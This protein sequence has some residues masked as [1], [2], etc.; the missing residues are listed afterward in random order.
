M[1]STARTLFRLLA[2]AALT[3]VLTLSLA[4]SAASAPLGCVRGPAG[5]PDKAYAV[6]EH[7]RTHGSAPAG[8][9]GGRRFENREGHLDND[10]GPFREYDVNRQV[11]G[12]NR[13]PQRIVLGP[14]DAASYYT[15]DHYTTFIT[16]Y[17]D[18][19]TA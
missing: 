11:S 8:Y 12:Q 5:V 7:V 4:T 6:A 15:P 1:F 9:V 10:L 17:G 19:C 2:G 18:S 13:G 16:M 14:S 3:L